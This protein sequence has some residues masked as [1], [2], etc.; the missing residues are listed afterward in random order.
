MG[1]QISPFCFVKW[2]PVCHIICKTIETLFLNVNNN[3]F[4]PFKKWSCNERILNT[5]ISTIK[6]KI[7]H[8]SR[9]EN[10]LLFKPPPPLAVKLTEKWLV[11]YHKEF[12]QLVMFGLF[13][14]DNIPVPV[15]IPDSQMP[16]FYYNYNLNLTFSIYLKCD[17][18]SLYCTI[19]PKRTFLRN[20]HCFVEQLLACYWES[21]AQTWRHLSALGNPF[22][23]CC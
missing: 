17:S 7:D 11:P 10:K 21:S 4:L 9:L 6:L 14:Q 22:Y 16:M 15:P 8:S 13:P 19:L 18:Y 1:L 12:L 2:S 20:V 3:S 23:S 5:V